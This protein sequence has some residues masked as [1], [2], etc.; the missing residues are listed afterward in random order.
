MTT[1]KLTTHG[2]ADPDSVWQQYIRPALWKQWSPQIS[3]VRIGNGD[4]LGTPNCD[5]QELAAWRD[6]CTGYP[7]VDAGMRQLQRQG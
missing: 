3:G 7:I 4:E 5:E 1:L 6:G 2:E